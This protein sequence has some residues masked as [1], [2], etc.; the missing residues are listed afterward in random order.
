MSVRALYSLMQS[1]E[2]RLGGGEGMQGIYGS[3]TQASMSRV[4]DALAA[5]TALGP[6]S[7]ML[8]VGAGLGRPLMHALVSHD[9][10]RAVGIELDDVKVAKARALVRNID[11]ANRIDGRQ[12]A[13][14]IDYVCSDIADAKAVHTDDVTHCY[15]FWEGVPPDAK[16]AF[17]RLVQKSDA[18]QGVAVVQRAVRGESPEQCMH[19]W[20]FGSLVLVNTFAVSMA[21]SGRKMTA[22][23]FRRDSGVLT[24]SPRTLPLEE[25]CTPKTQE[26]VTDDATPRDRAKAPKRRRLSL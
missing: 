7:V 11:R 19:G 12:L 22:Y 16:E 18:V 5:E 8:D 17:G 2:A 15:S 24:P 6:D 26:N 13:P 9:I 1:G 4:L 10:K 3:I 21:G 25:F 20:G 14:C 23:I